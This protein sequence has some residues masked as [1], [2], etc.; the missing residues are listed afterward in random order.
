MRIMHEQ[1]TPI[2]KESIQYERLKLEPI[3]G[4]EKVLLPAMTADQVEEVDPLIPPTSGIRL[5]ILD[6]QDGAA[7]TC[8]AS[9]YTMFLRLF[10]AISII[11]KEKLGRRARMVVTSDERPTS[12]MLVRHALQVF[13]FDGHELLVQT[14]AKKTISLDQFVHS[15]MSTPYSSATI[16]VLAGIDAVITVTASHN[17]VVWNGIKFYFKQPI[18]VAGDLLKE[19]SKKAINLVEVPLKAPSAVQLKGDDMET[20]ING[21]VQDVIKGIIPIQGIRGKPVVLWP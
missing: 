1:G 2:S 4:G 19:V 6:R 3:D 16:A 15:G 17:S 20:R 5:K 10:K 7:P 14:S 11:L 13:A 9:K 12:D 21:Y 18:P 8:P